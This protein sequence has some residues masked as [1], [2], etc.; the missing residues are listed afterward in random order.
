MVF[1][2]GV[3]SKLLGFA[4]EATLAS[5]FGASA[6]TD[7]YL[8]AMVIPA[9]LFG[10]VG[11]VITTVGIPLFSEHLHR[12]EKRRELAALVWG[13]FGAIC[14]L[15]AI[16][17]L[18]G[19]AASPWLVRLLAP[20]FAPEQAELAARLVRILM[21][22]V[23]IM[24]M[25][26]WAQGVLNAHHHFTAPALMGVPYNLLMIGGISRAAAA[27]SIAGVAWA[28]VLATASQLLIQVPALYRHGVL[29]GFRLYPGHPAL[30]R[31]LVLS[32]P[33]L[34]GLGA[35][36]L[37]LIVDRM[38][39]S[40]LEEG[41]ISAL[42]YAQR[43]L[44]LP[45]GLLALP[46]IT[47]LYPIFAQRATV[48][49]MAGFR[50]GLVRGLNVL[51]L[52][53][54]PVTVAAAV[55]REEVVR[56]V[57]QRGA[58]DERDAAMT[59]TALLWY[60]PG[61]LFLMWREL[62]NRAFYALQDTRTPMWTGLAA[63][64]ANIA[65]NLLLVRPLGLAGLALATS[66]SA[67]L[68][69]ALLL[70][71]L[72]RRAGYGLGGEVLA[73]SWRMALAASLV[74]ALLW[75]LGAACGGAAPAGFLGQGLRLLTLGAVGGAAYLLCCRLLKVGELDFMLALARESTRRAA[76]SGR[77]R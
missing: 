20:G 39:A 52:V 31:M 15:L 68:A 14:G 4:R 9:I 49:D 16:I 11:N 74:G 32:V 69:C 6:A 44:S 75:R 41:S 61:L 47:V 59:A 37:N 70:F 18:L 34:I 29:Q 64:A 45:Q 55:L 60:A 72:R 3:L 25:V 42:N 27:G 50:S 1:A 66:L 19:L 48:E 8:V 17:A 5:S 12:P 53:L 38:L 2:A 35:N 43:L 26:G 33:V 36:Q 63:V 46:V 28:T 22:M 71:A 10:L 54:I 40:T 23:V 56:F 21:P 13:S 73:A 67:A 77:R 57:F 51:A 30:K 24:G 58:F 7:A 65:L 76:R 62:L